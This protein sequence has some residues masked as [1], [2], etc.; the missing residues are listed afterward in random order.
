MRLHYFFDVVH[1]SKLVV[2]LELLLDAL[3]RL[4]ILVL[5]GTLVIRGSEGDG[6]V[7]VKTV[8]KFN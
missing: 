1:C 4:V 6:E 7:N 8:L 2:V 3:A 5:L